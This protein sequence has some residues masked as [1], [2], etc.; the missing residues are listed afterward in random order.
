MFLN[1]EEI[2]GGYNRSI[3]FD[4]NFNVNEKFSFFLVGA[5]TYSPGESGKRNNFAGNAGLL[6]QSDLWK[7]NIFYLDIENSFNP[8][9]GFL[10]R[11]GIKRTDGEIIFSPRLDI[12]PSVRQLFFT[13]NGNYQTNHNNRIFN[14]QVRS[15]ILINFENTS[16]ISFFIEREYEYLENDFEIRPALIIPQ[17]GYTSTKYNGRIQFDRTKAISG[18]FNAN[19][20][21]FFTGSTRGAGLNAVIRAH[22]RVLASMNYNYNEI[23]L[24]NGQFHTNKLS[25]RLSYAFSTELFYQR[26][27]SVD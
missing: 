4:S 11:A 21:D 23:K 24:P 12:L 6:F 19:W 22:A 16:S 9:M 13:V 15:T 3:G 17:T 26:I 20:G 18:S 1:K 25:T 8:E 10:K 7:Y 5:G 14:K 27:F 2:D